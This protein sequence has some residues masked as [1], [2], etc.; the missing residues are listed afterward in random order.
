MEGRG[1]EGRGGE[2]RGGEGRERITGEV[3]P[4]ALRLMDTVSCVWRILREECTLLYLIFF[5]WGGGGHSQI[6]QKLPRMVTPLI[7]PTGTRMSHDSEILS[8]G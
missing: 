8:V 7:P 1:G 2:G 3:H 4:M 5:F 6:T